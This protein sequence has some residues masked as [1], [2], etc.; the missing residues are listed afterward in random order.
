MLK[1][2]GRRWYYGAI[3]NDLSPAWPIHEHRLPY[4]AKLDVR[5][6]GQIDLVVMHCTELPDLAMAREV[7]FGLFGA[8]MEIT[9]ESIRDLIG[10]Q[11]RVSAEELKKRKNAWKPPKPKIQSG[12]LSRYASL[13]TSGSTGAVLKDRV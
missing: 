10:S 12:Y 6:I 9:G 3:M 7:I 1:A 4:E 11:Y 8:A 5:E 13:V 2:A